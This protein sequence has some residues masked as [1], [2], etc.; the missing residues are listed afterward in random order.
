MK[1]S[2]FHLSSP[3]SRRVKSRARGSH[4]NP[5]AYALTIAFLLVAACLFFASIKVAE[6]TPSNSIVDTV[7]RTT[8]VQKDAGRVRGKH[9]APPVL[10]YNSTKASSPIIPHT[11][12]FTYKHN[13]LDTRKPKLFYD[14]VMH[15]ISEYRS[16]WNE[17]GAHVSF[18]TDEDCIR[19][20]EKAE[21]RLVQHFEEGGVGSFKAD[22]CR[23]AALYNSGGY[24]FDI[25]LKVVQP[26]PLDNTTFNFVTV[27]ET[28]AYMNFF[29]AFIASTAN[30]PILKQALENMLIHYQDNSAFRGNL[31]P[32]TLHS[33]YES[34]SREMQQ[35]A[36]ILHEL[37]LD[38]PRNPPD[39]YKE[40]PRQIGE[41][42]CCNF[43][44]EDAK[45]KQVYFFSRIVGAS[46]T[47]KLANVSNES[48][49]E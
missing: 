38:H 43:V 19:E 6:N 29:Q 4:E 42:C 31:G 8:D 49:K 40:L 1:Q 21:P 2:S 26:V 34:S 23:I 13:I 28:A 44:V 12:F 41:G 35:K 39:I 10:P 45:Q 14:N 16:L 5:I 24:Y 22:I 7:N 47:C 11:L 32:V 30:H 37:N 3:R 17:P 9:E 25:D 15:T 48:A 27:H 46:G 18:L 36:W 20:I 33:A